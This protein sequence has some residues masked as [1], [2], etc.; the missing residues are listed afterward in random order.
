MFA[1]FILAAAAPQQEDGTLRARLQELVRKLG[2]DDFQTREA[3]EKEL[4][5]LPARLAPEIAALGAKSDDLEVK[6]RVARV[7]LAEP[8]P[9]LL[10]CSIG[11][12]RQGVH[13]LTNGPASERTPWIGRM[14]A[15]L[16]GQ[17]AAAVV[18][19][20]EGMLAS[21]DVGAKEF[22]L[23][24]LARFPTRDPARLLPFFDQEDLRWRASEALIAANDS[25]VVPKVV[26][27]FVKGGAAAHPAARVLEHFGPGDAID[28]VASVVREKEDLSGVGIRI[29]VRAGA[30]AEE[31]L[32]ALLA[33][34]PKYGAELVRALEELG[35][36]GSLPALRAWFK[37]HPKARDRDR[38]LYT[39][40]DREWARE[41]LAEARKQDEELSDL[42]LDEIAAAGG[43]ALR[44][45]VLGWLR[46]PGLKIGA[47]LHLLP[48][49]GAVG[50]TEDG[51]FLVEKL[52]ER[53]LRN[54]AGEA[55]GRLADP[56]HARAL[57]EAYKKSDSGVDLQRAVAA[58]PA[59]ALEEDLLEILSDPAG[60][61]ADGDVVLRLVGRKLT[62]RLRETLYKGI[63]EGE[64][65]WTS[66]R[67]EALRILVENVRPEDRLWIDKLRAHPRKDATVKVC[68]LLLAVRSG[69]TAAA[70]ELARILAGQEKF[71]LPHS[72]SSEWGASAH[73]LKWAAPSGATWTRA[74]AEAWRARPG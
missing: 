49:L 69:D 32:A 74:V 46:M 73:L 60:Y 34:K 48:L 10:A 2:D 9:K 37:E 31:A 40:R 17:N 51:A 54:A 38:V 64:I 3:A 19:A 70:P 13:R 58:L 36:E 63:L 7:A 22:A 11:E 72:T 6:T 14:V 52:K 15:A 24:G 55:L 21:P 39:F 61:R 41:K 25:S 26:E 44:D 47:Q 71:F 18:P 4:L 42:V 5:A 1:L 68:G 12:A 65:A 62:P 53:R 23:A 20:L 35:G 27:I 16:E 8:W 57:M 67:A 45:D 66:L 59:D 33:Q 30:R 50:R 28:R 43:P 56:S 29:L